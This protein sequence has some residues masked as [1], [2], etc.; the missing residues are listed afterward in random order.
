MSTSHLARTILLAGAAA[1]G[2]L[3]A[4]DEGSPWGEPPDAGICWPNSTVCNDGYS[5]YPVV[6]CWVETQQ[7][8]TV[9]FEH[10]EC[11]GLDEE[12][13]NPSPGS[14]TYGPAS[15]PFAEAGVRR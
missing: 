3:A 2:A 14:T 4:C 15:V 5:D 1:L 8:C 10:Q 13:P 9:G 12:C 11:R 6:C 7:C